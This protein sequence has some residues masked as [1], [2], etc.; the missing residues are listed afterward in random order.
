M[1]LCVACTA[2]SN[3]LGS[4]L[5]ILNLENSMCNFGEEFVNQLSDQ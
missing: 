5:P 1:I 4:R 2:K 3:Q